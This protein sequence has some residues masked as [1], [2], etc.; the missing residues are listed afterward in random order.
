VR[1]PEGGGRSIVEVGL[2]QELLSL[3]TRPGRIAAADTRLRQSGANALVVVLDV[4]VDLQR[5]YA[6]VQALDGRVEIFARRRQLLRE[7][8]DI[9]EA[10]VEAGEAARLDVLTIQGELSKLES[11]IL[12]LEADRRRTRV[13]LARRLGRPSAAAEWP[14]EP[15]TPPDP[16]PQDEAALIR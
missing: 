6:Q 16:P 3:L 8:V 5:R 14:L 2:A 13:E 11:E 10:R 9:S 1:L 12:A 7:L 4:M 15:W